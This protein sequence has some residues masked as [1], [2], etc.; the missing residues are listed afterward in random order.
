MMPALIRHP[1]FPEIFLTDGV[2]ARLV[3]RDEIPGLIDL[4]GRGVIELTNGGAVHDV[5]D[6]RLIGK[7][8]GGAPRGWEAY[9]A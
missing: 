7:I 3:A 9:A 1:D 4:A 8:L 6:R 2:S 5:T